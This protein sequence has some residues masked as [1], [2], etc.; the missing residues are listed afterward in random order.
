M[1]RSAQLDLLEDLRDDVE[2]LFNRH[3][4][5]PRVWY[6][7]ESLDFSQGRSFVDHPWSTTDYDLPSAV[8]SAVYVNLLTE[9]NLPYYTTTIMAHTRPGHP[10]T[11]WNHQW[12]MEEAR[13]AMAMR[14]WVH[15]SRCIDPTLLEDG[16]RIQMF[17]AV[18]PAPPSLADLLCYVA[19]Q[20]R[21]TQIAHRNT[22]FRLARDDKMGRTVLGLIAG[23]ETKHFLFYRDLASAGFTVAPSDMVIAALDQARAFAMPGI[24]IPGFTRHAVA[25]ARAGIYG[26]AQF[27]NDILEPLLT[28][29]G[30]WDLKDLTPT[31]EAARDELERLVATLRTRVDRQRS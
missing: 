2:R 31:G 27:T 4:E 6:P 24:A 18:V 28:Y 15:I 7:H 25:I 3:L 9:D 23:D 29:W 1:E 10:L 21:A 11:E 12:T 5:S 16:R 17:A 19:M 20:E 22:M 14:E 8:R 26:L 13:H 30:V